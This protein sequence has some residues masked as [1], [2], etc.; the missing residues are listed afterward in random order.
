MQRDLIL[1]A[2]WQ[3][4]TSSELPPTQ[5]QKA[6]ETMGNKQGIPLL[7]SDTLAVLQLRLSMD[8]PELREY[9]LHTYRDGTTFVFWFWSEYADKLASLLDLKFEPHATTL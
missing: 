9:S 8:I 1:V 5:Y 4:I 6:I 7:R 2:S 3:T